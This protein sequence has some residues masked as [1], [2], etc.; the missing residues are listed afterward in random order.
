M[1]DYALKYG[2]AEYA[3]KYTIG[4]KISVLTENGYLKRAFDWLRAEMEK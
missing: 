2:V 1:L 3:I 4:H